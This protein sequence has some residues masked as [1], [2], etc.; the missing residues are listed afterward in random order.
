MV[1]FGRPASK[2]KSGTSYKALFKNLFFQNGIILAFLQNEWRLLFILKSSH[3]K[4]NLI[5]LVAI[6][7]GGFLSGCSKENSASTQESVRAQL[8]SGSWKSTYFY[9]GNTDRTVSLSGYAFTFS[10]GDNTTA[11]NGML[12]QNGTWNVS[13]NDSQASLRMHYNGTEGSEMFITLSGDWSVTEHS[14]SK[15]VLQRAGAEGSGP[16][17]FVME[18]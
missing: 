17:Q 7:S 2:L 18:K 14:N 15:M 1:S 9:S 13:G 11:S 5:V 12:S 8:M 4:L 6:V 3:M 10:S 16:D